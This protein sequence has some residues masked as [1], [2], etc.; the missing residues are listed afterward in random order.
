METYS[1]RGPRLKYNHTILHLVMVQQVL[2]QQNWSN[3]NSA[4]Q[5]GRNPGGT[6]L[7]YVQ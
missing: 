6:R 1:P 3:R 2:R 4:R 7:T 5:K